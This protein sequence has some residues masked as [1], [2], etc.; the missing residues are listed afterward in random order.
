MGKSIYVLSGGPKP[1]GTYSSANE[2]SKTWEWGWE[3]SLG[4]VGMGSN[5]Y[6]VLPKPLSIVEV[7]PFKS[8]RVKQASDGK[9]KLPEEVIR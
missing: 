7:A 2:A 8:V 9:G 3:W 4:M 5:L 6:G 1:G